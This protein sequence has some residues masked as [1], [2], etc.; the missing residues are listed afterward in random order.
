M[1]KNAIL[2][3]LIVFTTFTYDVS[4]SYNSNWLKNIESPKTA[5]YIWVNNRKTNSYTTKKEKDNNKK[6]KVTKKDLKQEIK[7]RKKYH[8]SLLSTYNQSFKQEHLDMLAFNS[9]RISELKKLL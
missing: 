3:F 2:I 1:K 5:W 9:K 4:A 6:L 7:K 8:R